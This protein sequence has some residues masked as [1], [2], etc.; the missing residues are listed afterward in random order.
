MTTKTLPGIKAV[1]EIIVELE[2]LRSQTN[3][4]WK[5]PLFSKFYK[6]LTLFG[7]AN[8]PKTSGD[9]AKSKAWHA[10][11]ETS[12]DLFKVEHLN[13]TDLEITKQLLLMALELVGKLDS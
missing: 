1:S 5:R 12:M 11:V 10:L 8:P 13:E 2:S 9:I 6:A 4:D 7:W 3:E